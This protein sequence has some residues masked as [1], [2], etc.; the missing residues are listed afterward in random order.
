[1]CIASFKYCLLKTRIL[2]DTYH[3]DGIELLVA[4]KLSFL[5]YFDL[6]IGYYNALETR[7]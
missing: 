5:H 7:N 1:M 3:Q 6:L 4:I 2:P